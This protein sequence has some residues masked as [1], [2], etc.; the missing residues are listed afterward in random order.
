MKNKF[1]L[2]KIGLNW[3][4]YMREDLCEGNDEI[5]NDCYKLKKEGVID[6][7]TT[8]NGFVFMT[9][10]N[11]RVAT[12]LTHLRDLQSLFPDFYDPT[13]L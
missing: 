9:P 2:S 8:K 5:K 7:F 6:K 10:K 4:I 13:R 12:K 11:S 1:R 3:K